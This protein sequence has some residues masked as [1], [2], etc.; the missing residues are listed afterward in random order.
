[1]ATLAGVSLLTT[2]SVYRLATH[3]VEDRVTD[4]YGVDW[5]REELP[6]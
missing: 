6:T 2:E 4:F 5:E 1:M 3:L